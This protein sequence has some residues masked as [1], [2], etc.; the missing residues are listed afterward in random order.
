GVD[1]NAKNY[2]EAE[3]DDGGPYESPIT[4][5]F[6]RVERNADKLHCIEAL[7]YVKNHLKEN[8]ITLENNKLPENLTPTPY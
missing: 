6:E 4:E 2:Y 3:T 5:R 1:L 8:N 7:N